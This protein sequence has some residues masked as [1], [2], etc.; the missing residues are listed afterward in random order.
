M[1]RRLI[2][3]ALFLMSLS[4]TFGLAM[5]YAEQTNS[6]ILIPVNRTDASSGKQMYASYCAPCHGTDGRGHGPA[7]P[8]LKMQPVDLTGL[9][10]AN[11]GRFPDAHVVAVL[12]FGAD[13]P[14]HGSAIM[15]VWGPILGKMNQSNAQERSLRV[16]N[17]SAYL[18]SIQIK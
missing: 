15:P 10:K 1:S 17:L 14:A 11:N 13:M 6:K 9:A 8:A 7:A 5:G 4:V 16:A 3:I 12:Q 18:R 2:L